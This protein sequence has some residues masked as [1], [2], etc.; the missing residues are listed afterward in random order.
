MRP[1]LFNQHFKTLQLSWLISNHFGQVSR[2]SAGAS[3]LETMLAR[4]PVLM[5]LHEVS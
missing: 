4:M 2:R 3:V 1:Q 5:L